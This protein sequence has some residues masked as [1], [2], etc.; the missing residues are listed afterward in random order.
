[1]GT[2][3]KVL[4]YLT[5]RLISIFLII[6]ILLMATFIAYDCANIYVILEEGM[7]MRAETV[8]TNKEA[9]LLDKFFT[10]HCIDTDNLLNSNRYRDYIITDYDYNIKMKKVWAWP[11]SRRTK[12][13]IQE[14]VKDISGDLLSSESEGEATSKVP[15]PKW[16][17]GEKIVELKKINRRWVIDEITLKRPLEEFD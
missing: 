11:W 17:N 9:P 3:S 1:M 4:T 15:I 8:L 16:E 2:G 6:L 10:Q 7:G 12:V 5:K 14:I 13:T